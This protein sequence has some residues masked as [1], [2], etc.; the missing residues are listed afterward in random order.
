[1]YKYEMD[2]S[3]ATGTF[4]KKGP[5]KSLLSRVMQLTGR[6]P[7]ICTYNFSLSSLEGFSD[8]VYAEAYVLVNQ[9]LIQLGI[10]L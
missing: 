3:R 6:L 8:P 9:Y 5:T 1:M 7:Y 4:E 10:T 2:I